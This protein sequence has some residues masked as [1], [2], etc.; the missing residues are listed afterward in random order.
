LHAGFEIYRLKS[1]WPRKISVIRTKFRN[2][3]SE[4]QIKGAK[5]NGISRDQGKILGAFEGQ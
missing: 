4:I 1:S 2:P 3:E 5:I